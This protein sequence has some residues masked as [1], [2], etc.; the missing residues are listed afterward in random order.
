M[1][2]YNMQSHYTHEVNEDYRKGWDSIF[3][4]TE[5]KDNGQEGT[6]ETSSGEGEE[7]NS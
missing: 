2:N 1:A 6:A 7:G 5:D 3:K 4:K